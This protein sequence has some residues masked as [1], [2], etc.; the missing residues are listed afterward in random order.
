M[1]EEAGVP[2]QSRPDEYRTSLTPVN[3]IKQVVYCSAK[4]PSTTFYI[5]LFQVVL[6]FSMLYHLYN[7]SD[8]L[9]ARDDGA[10]GPPVAFMAQR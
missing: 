3:Y 1:Q 6:S 9:R 2:P 8:N 10:L 7:Y 4:L 5:W